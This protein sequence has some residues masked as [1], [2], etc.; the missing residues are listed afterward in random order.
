M[1]FIAVLLIALGEGAFIYS[2]IDYE[3]S[4]APGKQIRAGE[5]HY[6]NPLLECDVAQDSIN[7]PKINFEPA[8]KEYVAEYKDS[9]PDINSIAVYVRY[10]N[11]GPTLGVDAEEEF[12]PASLL[13]VPYMMSLYAE[14][15]DNPALLDE[16]VTLPSGAHLDATQIFPPKHPLVPGTTYT[17]DEL[18][19]HMITES[20]NDALK[21]ISSK[22]IVSDTHH[23]E[24]YQRLGV[25]LQR[26]NDAEITITLRQYSAFFRILFNASYLSQKYSEKALSILTN[27]T[28]AEGIPKD[29][30]SGLEIAHKFGEYESMEKS[31]FLHDCGI[32]YY[33]KVPYLLCIMTKGKNI[34]KQLEAIQKVSRFTFDMVNNQ[35][36]AF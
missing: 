17:I 4:L 20:D 26:D 36:H 18:I 15:L 24:M 21:L 5:G 28:F 10:L 14:A 27:S 29:L 3:L 35:Y 6:T 22:F 13:K 30:P 7:A 8:L 31:I 2:D 12:V 23:T 16:K 19:S 25:A 33:P 11:N 1:A 34:D 32:I 9:N